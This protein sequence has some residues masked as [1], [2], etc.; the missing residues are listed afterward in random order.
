[1]CTHVHSLKVHFRECYQEP[2]LDNKISKHGF[3]FSYFPQK[4]HVIYCCGLVAKSCLTLCDP[5]DCGLPDSS[6]HGISQARILEWVAISFSRGPGDWTHMD[7]THI[8][9]IDRQ[10]IYSWPTREVYTPASRP[11]PQHTPSPQDLSSHTRDWTHT[12]C[13]AGGFFTTEPSRKP[14][15]ILI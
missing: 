2:S 6:V 11:E 5:M 15:K 14:N 3:I 9:C 10:I 1:M 13:I 8:S 4:I 7:W 12:L